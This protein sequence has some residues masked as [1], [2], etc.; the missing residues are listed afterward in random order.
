[1]KWKY[2]TLV[3]FLCSCASQGTPGGGDY[4]YTPPVMLKSVP[5]PNSTNYRHP[6]IELT[7]DE[8][9]SIDKP[10]EKVIITPPQ[11]KQPS[12]RAIGKKVLV[13]LKDTIIANTTYTLD[14]TN[15]IVDNNERNAIDGFAFAFSTGDILDTLIVS[16]I[17]LD[18]ENLE[19]M[20]NIMVGLHSTLDDSAFTALPFTRTTMTNER[21]RFNIR[22]VAPGEYRVFA[23]KDANKNYRYDP[24]AEEIAFFDSIV[25]PSFEPAI[26]YDTTWVDSM[27]VDTIREIHY[28]RFL[29]DDIILR[30]FQKKYDNQYLLKNERPQEKQIVYHFN[31][32]AALPPKIKLLETDSA[33]SEIQNCFITEYAP[34]GKD[35]TYWIS[36]SLVYQRDTLLL[37]TE[38]MITDTLYN[39]VPRTDTLRFVWKHKTPEQLEKEL[40]KAEKENKKKKNKNE[41][42]K[43]PTDIFMKVQISSRQLMD[44]FDTVKIVFEEPLRNFDPATIKITQ[45]IDTLWHPA[46]IPIVAD[47]ANPRSWFL[48][49]IW[50]YGEEYSIRIDSAALFSIYDRWNDSIVNRFKFKREEDYAHFYITIQGSKQGFGELL[51]RSGRTIRRANLE[52]ETLAFENLAPG[53]Y[54]IRYFDDENGNGKWDEGDY[55]EKRQPEGVYYNPNK[56]E[57]RKYQTVSQTWNI[58]ELP[59]DKQKPLEITK[60][61][62]V[63]K[64]KRTQPSAN[65][66]KNRSGQ[67]GASGSNTLN[68]SLTR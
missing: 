12:V 44:V 24:P 52:D 38:Y 21:G 55:A 1:M 37:E 49:Y 33:E 18:A 67:S 62:P 56:W 43:K 39:L 8:Y 25:V 53:T 31:S 54:Y 47:P 2:Y 64:R 60:N 65:Q 28:T 3:L 61:K 15:G 58:H 9:I 68:R 23:L 45:R 13:E 51:D 27:T 19:P 11:L 50:D 30:L 16:G 48:D 41:P 26:R 36:D 17:L 63:E 6:K 10:S 32:S 40:K 5:A 59:I 14:F 22:N 29:P 35:V 34:E 66:G 46:D 7:F 42:E 4:D 57:F 20:P